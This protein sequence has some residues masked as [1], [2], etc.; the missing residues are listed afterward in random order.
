M[1]LLLVEDIEKTKGRFYRKTTTAVS[2]TQ[3]PSFDSGAPFLEVTAEGS[4]WERATKPLET[5][6]E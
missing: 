6:T 3:T 5:E 1:S 4:E 2:E